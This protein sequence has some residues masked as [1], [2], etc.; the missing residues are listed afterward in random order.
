[1]GWEPRRT[2]SH[3]YE[4]GRLIRTVEI[5]ETDWDD[6]S[7]DLAMAL[8]IYEADQCPGCAQPLAETTK[9]ENE[10]LYVAGAA[11]RCHYCTASAQG[12]ELYADAPQ[13]QALLLPV[14]LRKAANVSG[15]GDG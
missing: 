10:G 12:S 11:I 8:A 14:E 15:E 5:S 6:E 3:T 13:S 9:P 1:M 4:N 7:R 2:Y